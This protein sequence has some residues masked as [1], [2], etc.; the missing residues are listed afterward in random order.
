MADDIDDLLDEVEFKYCG[1]GKAQQEKKG[2]QGKTSKSVN[3]TSS[4]K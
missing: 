4:T 1:N 3:Q 2:S